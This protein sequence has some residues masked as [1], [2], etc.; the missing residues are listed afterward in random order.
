M[1]IETTLERFI[2]DELLIGN[3]QMKI[4]PETSLIDS[5]IID[6]L[7][8]I[9][10]ILFIEERFGLSIEDHEVVPDNFDSLQSLKALIASKLN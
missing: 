9:R 6:S 4:A 2:V 8:L 1:N 7:S 3:R 5:G 10:L